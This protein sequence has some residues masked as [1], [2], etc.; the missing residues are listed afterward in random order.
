MYCNKVKHFPQSF[1][2]NPSLILSGKAKIEGLSKPA[3]TVTGAYTVKP[4]TGVI[5]D[6]L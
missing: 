5:V 1:T 2:S 4:F 3:N 6:V